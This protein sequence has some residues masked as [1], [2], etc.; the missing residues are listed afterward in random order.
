MFIKAGIT[1]LCEQELKI[2]RAA[3]TCYAG[4]TLPTPDIEPTDHSLVVKAVS[5]IFLRLTKQMDRS[6]PLFL[7]RCSETLSV[8]FHFRCSCHWLQRVV[9]DFLN[10]VNTHLKRIISKSQSSYSQG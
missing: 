4:R 8:K 6:N 5:V 2:V 7:L 1:S 9:I 3:K 10:G